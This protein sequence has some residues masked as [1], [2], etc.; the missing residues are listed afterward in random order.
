M[1]E[2]MTD[3]TRDKFRATIVRVTESA[4]RLN[5]ASLRAIG[6]ETLSGI[7]E[8]SLLDDTAAA[9]QRDGF[10]WRTDNRIL[11]DGSPWAWVSGLQIDDDPRIKRLP[12]GW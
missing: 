6:R 2:P 11:L 5:D 8:G 3:K 4:K 1:L 12:I 9:G 10:A 7:P